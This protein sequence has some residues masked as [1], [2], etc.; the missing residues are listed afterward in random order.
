MGIYKPKSMALGMC[1]PPTPAGPT[2]FEIEAR[3][4]KLTPEQY[5]SSIELRRWILKNFT[6]V[7]VPEYLLE[8]LGLLA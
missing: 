8:K 5:S 2:E 3:R 7:Y 6:R 1:A 4:L